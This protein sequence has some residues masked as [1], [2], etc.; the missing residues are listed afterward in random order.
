MKL[1][2][3]IESGSGN[4]FSELQNEIENLVTGMFG[5]RSSSS[6][7][8]PRA[9]IGETEN[10]YSV[11]LELPGVAAEGVTVEFKD[12]SLEISGEK[13]SSTEEGDGRKFLRIER[14]FG[15]FRRR[16]E[17]GDQVDAENISAD[18]DNGILLVVVP[19][20]PKAMSRKIEIRK[21]E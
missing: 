3:R 12:G 8:N 11:T 21:S 9:D 5:E 1:V 18:F 14:Q 16:F 17:F 13:K 4:P 19:K 6:T 2:N 15:S 10:E 7:L 20:S